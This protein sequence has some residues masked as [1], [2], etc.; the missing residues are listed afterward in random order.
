MKNSLYLLY[1]LCLLLA[2]AGCKKGFLDARPDKSL[3]IPTT[4]NDMQALLDNSAV[5][6]QTPQIT[7]IADGDF[8]T[9]DA[10]SK[11]WALDAE[12]NA[13]TWNSEIW[14]T[15]DPPDW[16]TSY[17]QIFYANVVLDGLPAIPATGANYNAVKG[18]ALFSRAFAYYNL[19][20]VFAPPYRASSSGTDLGLSIRL[21]S[22]VTQ[23]PSRSSLQA[24]YDQVASDLKA[25]RFLLPQVVTGKSR[26][27]LAA[28]YGLLARVYLIEGDYAQA[29]KY[30]DSCL[31]LGNALIDYNTLNTTAAKPF[32]KAIPNAN[33]EMVYYAVQGSYTFSTNAA[34][35]ADTVLY[36]SYA[37]ND[38]R[39]VILYKATG[40][41]GTFK[42]NYSGIIV[43][44]SGIATDELYLVRAECF[45]R[46]GL[47][48]QALA[49]LNT[50]L[51]KRWKTGTFVPLTTADAG[52]ALALILTERRKELLGRTMRWTDLKRLNG[53]SRFAVTLTRSANGVS[54]TL[55]PDSRRYAFPLPADEVTLSGA[56][57]NP[58]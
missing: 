47:T 31:Q 16:T 12:R 56:V 42:G 27:S 11:S 40:I 44:F 48:V 21:Q 57:Q 19:L 55:A 17:Q 46:Q 1:S 41:S 51:A 13:Y 36:R 4:L 53:D 58:Q 7:S 15:F 32:P 9:T 37:A 30:A 33:A 2:L 38:L 14:E 20:Q 5:F 6:N 50:L 49:D 24:T 26:P 43:Y 18:T 8:Y 35:L 23:H 45:A 3:L 22:D 10:A 29:G 39:K 52:A 34:T 54:Y 25:A 28:A